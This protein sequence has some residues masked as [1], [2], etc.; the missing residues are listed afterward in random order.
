MSMPYRQDR[1]R[2]RRDE[3]DQPFKDAREAMNESEAELDRQASPGDG[4]DT[5]EG[6]D[7][8]HARQEAEA[9]ERLGDIG[10][11]AAGEQE[12]S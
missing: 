6:E 8:R 10:D 3:G 7:E 1:I 4:F 11:E 9:S 5:P 12:S 2:E